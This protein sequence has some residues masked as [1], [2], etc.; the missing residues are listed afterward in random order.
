MFGSLLPGE[1][2]ALESSLPLRLGKNPWG[3]NYLLR[4]S[5][6][7]KQQLAF[8]QQKKSRLALPEPQRFHSRMPD[9]RLT[10]VVDFCDELLKTDQFTDW[11]AA[12]NGLQFENRGEVRRV[13]AA[14]D[15]SLATIRMA[16]AIQAD[17]LV[18]HHGLFWGTTH[19]WIGKRAELI[20]LVVENDLAVYSSH[21]PL[22]AHPRIGNNAR[23]CAALGLK[24]LK[25]F[26]FTK[27]QYL[28]FQAPARV[29]RDRLVQQLAEAVERQPIVLPGGPPIC[30]R[31]G[32]VTGGAGNEVKLAAQEGVDTFITGEGA[33]WTHALAEELG[34][35]ILYGGHYNTET[36]G[37]K[38]L[39]AE[40][41]RRFRLPWTF[42]H[43]PSGL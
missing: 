12:C 16:I 28:G 41:S 20:R 3:T 37:V 42:L 1:V 19:P 10:D 7:A 31:V 23:L 22:D 35:N 38:A 29:P 18:V 6:F 24:R 40:I 14:V 8:A 39:A 13:A 32:V 36:F 26:F 4:H 9:A 43:H 27:G 21:L 25:P 34:V 5:G 33:H 30:R 17:L 2:G 15:A 11:E